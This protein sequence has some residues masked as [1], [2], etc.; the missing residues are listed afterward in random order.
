MP[1]FPYRRRGEKG[2][3]V[4][5]L[6]SCP[7]AGQ[8]VRTHLWD[9]VSGAWQADQVQRIMMFKACCFEGLKQTKNHR[10]STSGPSFHTAQKQAPIQP[11][12]HCGPRYALCDARLLGWTAGV[13]M[14]EEV[15]IAGAG[16]LQ[17][18]SVQR[19]KHG[20]LST[21]HS[22]KIASNGSTSI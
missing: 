15:L 22:K 17:L 2:V 5:L 1:C 18:F 7:G 19:I 9:Q 3:G 13:N 21:A 6:L 8:E 20:E 10:Y 14:A 11:C 4:T 16:L 12:S